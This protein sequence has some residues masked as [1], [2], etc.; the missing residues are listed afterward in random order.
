LRQK[1]LLDYIVDF[2]CH[3]LSLVIE[4]DGDS[5]IGNEL[6]DENRTRELAKE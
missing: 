2:Y 4:I 1:P 3:E 5:H 6:Y